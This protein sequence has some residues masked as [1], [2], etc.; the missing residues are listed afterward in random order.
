MS[1]DITRIRAKLQNSKAQELLV[2]SPTREQ[3]QAKATFWSGVE[4]DSITDLSQITQ[5]MAETH[6]RDSRIGNWWG[7][8]GFREWF[9]NWDEFRQRLEF[10][11]NHSLDQLETLLSDEKVN[12]NAKV[13]AIKLIMELSKKVPSKGAQEQYLDEKVSQMNKEQLEEFLRSRV[14]RLIPTDTDK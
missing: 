11:A 10:L 8:P 1:I 9:C 14:T 12:A 6:G 4:K 3:K 5:E 7:I 2:F 13:A